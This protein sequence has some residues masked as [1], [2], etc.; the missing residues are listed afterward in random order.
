MALDDLGAWISR[1]RSEVGKLLARFEENFGYEPDINEIRLSTA[2]PELDTSDLP[3]QVGA[4][5]RTIDE[6]SWPDVGNGY[7][8]GPGME[9]IGRFHRGDP[10]VV[11]VDSENHRSLMI[12]SDGGGAYFVVDLD[13]GGAVLHVLEPAVQGGVIRGDVRVVG[14]DLDSFLDALLENVSAVARGDEPSF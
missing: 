12:G 9:M 10:G 8:L 14:Q 7:F 1:A 4:F 6:I 3:P 5:F 11:V 2:H 13:A